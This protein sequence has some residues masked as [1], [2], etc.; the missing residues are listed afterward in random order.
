MEVKDGVEYLSLNEAATYTG[1]QRDT[2][3]HRIMSGALDAVVL[4]ETGTGKFYG[5]T[6]EALDKT[7]QIGRVAT[8][9][10]PVEVGDNYLTVKQ[11]SKLTGLRPGTIGYRIARGQIPATKVQTSATGYHWYIHKDAVATIAPLDPNRGNH[12]GYKRPD[13]TARNKAR[14]FKQSEGQ[15]RV[16]P[17]LYGRVINGTAGAVGNTKSSTT[18]MSTERSLNGQ[19][20]QL[21]ELVAT[22]AATVES[23]NVVL[24]FG[25]GN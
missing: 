10:S 12:R 11:L 16:N 9:N 25:N 20:A 4:A 5:V 3:R 13:V 17:A 14:A 19:L 18:V 8:V 7:P 1:I 6:R 22:G 24:R 21:A 2:L 23:M 15:P